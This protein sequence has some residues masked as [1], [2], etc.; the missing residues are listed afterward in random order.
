LKEFI[1]GRQGLAA[2]PFVDQLLREVLDWSGESGQPGQLDDIT[3]IVV[4]VK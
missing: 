3:L 1:E 2:E 4:D